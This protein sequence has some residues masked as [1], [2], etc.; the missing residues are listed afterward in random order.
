[1][2]AHHAVILGA[3]AAGTAAARALDGQNNIQTTIVGQTD[4]TPYTRMLIKGIAYGPA[5]PELIRLP[6]PNATFIADTA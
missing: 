4:E 3:G 6:M 2:T 1:M 5:S